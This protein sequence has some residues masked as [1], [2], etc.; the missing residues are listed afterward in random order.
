MFWEF[1]LHTTPVLL[2]QRSSD[3]DDGTNGYDTMGFGFVID[4][5]FGR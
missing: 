1:S 3:W 5:E 4:M 2:A